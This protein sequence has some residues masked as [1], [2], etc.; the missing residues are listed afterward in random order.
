MQ[1][2][3]YPDPKQFKIREFLV[4]FFGSLIPGFIFVFLTV[5]A[6]GWPLSRLC[7][8]MIRSRSQLQVAQKVVS[9]NETNA[10]G[11]INKTGKEVDSW[12]STF[13]FEIIFF[14]ITLSYVVGHF[15][16]RRTPKI[17]DILSVWRTKNEL[18][19]DRPAVLLGD[20]KKERRFFSKVREGIELFFGKVPKIVKKLE[21][22]KKIDVQ[23]PYLYIWEYLEH[24]GLHHLAKIIPWKGEDE[25]THKY[26]SKAFINLL[27]IR[28][29]FD[30][31]E[32]CG[33]ITRNEA[34][35]RLMSSM[36]YMS[37]YLQR[38]GILSF[39]I[40]L[41]TLI[42]TGMINKE[43]EQVCLICWSP[44][45]Y[46]VLIIIGTWL[47]R[48]IIEKFFHYQRVREIVYV[49]ETAYYASN[50]GIFVPDKS[51]KVPFPEITGDLG[52]E[53]AAI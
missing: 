18:A 24:R 36:W 15:F 4:D 10:E 1:V 21:K 16:F 32:K 29:E 22:R 17:P 49:L 42:V 39:V 33:T 14:S 5:V 19:G 2:R 20:I 11:G 35:V 53:G 40:S 38:I 48:L 34:H 51:E 43:W 12:F 28:L 47:T 37:C 3:L 23:F 52:C 25:E 31:P 7:D 8:N 13:K 6:L 45:M 41:G 27:K 30:F 9:N 50:Y 26:R 44:L 46:S